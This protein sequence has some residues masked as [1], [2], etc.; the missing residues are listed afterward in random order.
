M[1]NGL[2]HELGDPMELNATY[3]PINKHRPLIDITGTEDRHNISDVRYGVD[4][5]PQSFPS[6]SA[7]LYNNDLTYKPIDNSVPSNFHENH[8]VPG[9]SVSGKYLY[10][11]TGFDANQVTDLPILSAHLSI[12][13]PQPPLP[14]ANHSGGPKLPEEAAPITSGN[15]IDTTSQGQGRLG[16]ASIQ[17]IPN[18]YV[19]GLSTATN[20]F[21]KDD[22]MSSVLSDD[23]GIGSS[24]FPHSIDQSSCHITNTSFQSSRSQSVSLAVPGPI[25]SSTPSLVSQSFSGTSKTT[26]LVNDIQKVSI[27]LPSRTLSNGK[28]LVNLG[29]L[30]DGGQSQDGTSIPTASTSI[31]E[32]RPARKTKARRADIC[33][34]KTTKERI[35]IRDL[36][37]DG[38]SWRKYG[39]KRLPNNAHPKSYFRCSVPGCHAKRYVTETDN[40]VLK[41][42]YI[43]EHNH[44][45]SSRIT[46]AATNLMDVC[47]LAAMGQN[48]LVK[49]DIS[50]TMLSKTFLDLAI[51]L[52]PSMFGDEYL[53]LNGF[54]SIVLDDSDRRYHDSVNGLEITEIPE[55]IY[56]LSELVSIAIS[57][58]AKGIELSNALNLAIVQLNQNL[59]ERSLCAT[60]GQE[61]NIRNCLKSPSIIMPSE[62]I[63]IM[64]GVSSVSSRGRKL[65]ISCK[66]PSYEHIESSIDFFRWK[67]Y[68]YKAQTKSRLDS[69]SYYRCSFFNCPARR[70]IA[71]FYSVCSDGTETIESMIVQYENQH[72]HAPDKTR[73][74][75]KDCM[76]L[77]KPLD[78]LTAKLA[79]SADNSLF[80]NPSS[81]LSI[82]GLTVAQRPVFTPLT[83]AH[84]TA[85]INDPTGSHPIP[86]Q[87]GMPTRFPYGI[88]DTNVSPQGT[89]IMPNI[90]RTDSFERASCL[91]LPHGTD[92][93]ALHEGLHGLHGDQ[94]LY[95]CLSTSPG[96]NTSYSLNAQPDNPINSH[97]NNNSNNSNNYGLVPS[98][99]F[100]FLNQL[101]HT[102]PH[103]DQIGESIHPITINSIGSINKIPPIINNY[104]NIS[105]NIERDIPYCSETI[106]EEDKDLTL[107][108]TDAE[109]VS[110]RT[111][112]W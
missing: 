103:F 27:S 70:T 5:N 37:S 9:L 111:T 99:S 89:Q 54:G 2:P 56:P 92:S 68:G 50:F 33:V 7:D 62:D 8:A 15:L 100:L 32:A 25:P 24:S 34:R 79:K 51:L 4:D 18:I 14:V 73:M 97:T 80:T 93:M 10:N 49:S 91:L 77:L 21:M 52:R 48:F 40:R 90:H 72:T 74:P 98:N 81:Y 43:G 101:N 69:K 22:A 63:S 84:I 13:L 71:F 26:T 57:F 29:E 11:N 3:L 83:P 108:N 12:P 105:S 59:R 78:S 109:S 104:V 94:N 1:K 38:Y 107:T 53:V 39:S 86:M 112:L 65:I 110:H 23:S 55:A 16:A 85:P 75:Y 58:F 87:P 44:G 82:A 19:S 42:E 66:L 60:R 17:D 67:K 76:K 46:H 61:A 20:V 36:P 88:A 95:G 96:H 35:T 64:T 102:Q 106:R 47:R 6:L 31:S 41:T 45:K 28:N 30:D